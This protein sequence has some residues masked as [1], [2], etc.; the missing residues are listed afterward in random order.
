MDDYREAYSYRL[1]IEEGRIYDDLSLN[2]F[3]YPNDEK[4]ELIQSHSNEN[5][6]V[7]EV[8]EENYEIS[9]LHLEYIALQ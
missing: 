5:A 2:D 4:V 7:S 8:L 9:A 6:N 1:R 3:D